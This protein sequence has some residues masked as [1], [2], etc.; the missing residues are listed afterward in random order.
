MKNKIFSVWFKEL[1]SLVFVQS[2]QA[3]LL[4]IMLSVVVKLYIGS[5]DSYV[6]QQSMG[7]YAI[8]IL[9]LIPRVE[10][11]V[12]KIFGLGSGVMDDS[13][14]GGRRSLLKTGLALKLGSSVLNNAG[15]V[16]G[17]VGMMAGAGIA[18]IR[19]NRIAKN[20]DDAAKIKGD[21]SKLRLG[22]RNA[23]GN[24]AALSGTQGASG[25]A[26]GSYSLDDLTSAI[27]SA[28]A[29]DYAELNRQKKHEIMQRGLK[30]LQQATSGIVET[31]GAMAGASI[32]GIVGLGTGGDDVFQDMLIGAGIGDK[33]GHAATDLTLGTVVA[34]NELG[35]QYGV[36]RREVQKSQKQ[37]ADAQKEYN[38]LVEKAKTQ[39]KPKN[40]TSSQLTAE[41]KKYYDKAV[42]AKASGDMASYH[43]NM[44]I[45]AGVRK[46][47]NQNNSSSNV[48]TKPTIS[49][50]G[51][52]VSGSG[53]T[54][55]SSSSQPRQTTQRVSSTT[56][57]K[58]A[59]NTS[60]SKPK[61][62]NSATNRNTIPNNTANNSNS[63]NNGNNTRTNN[64]NTS[65][66]TGT[67]GAIQTNPNTSNNGA[68]GR[69]NRT[70]INDISDI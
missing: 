46:H 1:C 39:N 64:A 28:N 51:T 17:G 5:Q 14:M 43:K 33:I 52:R 55:G 31:G 53:S 44:G 49:G 47:Q 67:A 37:V 27:K 56:N 69:I 38:E 15:K 9:A 13:M 30:G 70:G 54:S 63:N 65:R 62:D 58:P 10:L 24:N 50:T 3:L 34:A 45:A 4:T 2:M 61:I 41:Q 21:T 7:V 32:G 42:K 18:G 6:A 20:N 12:K 16:I 25:G 29:P 36:G 57:T 66:L 22:A 59:Q 35:Y 68:N 19:Q 40:T 60:A 8:L 48:N 11:L 23:Q 26:L